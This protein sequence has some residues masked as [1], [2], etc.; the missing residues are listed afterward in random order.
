MGFHNFFAYID[1]GTGSML[2]T[3]ILGV[4][5]TGVFVVRGLIIKF[6]F[7]LG[8]GKSNKEN[9]KKIPYV[10]FSD[11]KRYWN[12]FKPVCDEFEKR[13]IPLSYL[14]ASPDDPALEESYQYVKAEF[15]GEGNKAFAR[16]NMM[17]AGTCL[18]TTPGLDVLQWKRS[19]FV[20]KYVHIFHAIDDGSMYRMF[21]LDYYDSVLLNAPVQE[22]PLRKLEELRN[23][24]PKETLVV[25]ST[26]LDAM[27]E[28]A[29]KEQ[30]IVSGEKRNKV[31]LCAP[32]WGASSILNRYGE[33]FLNALKKT[34]YKI[35][36]RP[37]PQSKTA[38]PELL[39][40]LQKKFPENES[41]EWNFDNDNFEVLKSADILISDFSGVV[42][43]YSFIF[44]KPIIYADTSLD[45]S[46]YDAAWLE[47]EPWLI[48]TLPSIG[49]QL[50]PSDF[51]HMK[52][53]IDQVADSKEYK[54]GR[55]AARD[56]GWS[57]R[58]SAAK[59][60]VDYLVRQREVT[61]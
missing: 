19:K 5:T 51:D 39:E 42:F 30:T 25:G 53:I 23:L 52:E 16:L 32:T 21:G 41:F 60:I 3:I 18:S 38:D 2:F 15:I 8:G 35:I 22:A 24:P 40:D 7:G 17:S 34:G 47:G 10:I 4:V 11:S 56:E 49:K 28:R 43:E 59:N 12:V 54:A 57:Q 29:Q 6:K 20:D 45:K 9:A 50:E 26:H 14:T 44:D 1:P 37:H 46:P 58:G 61:A 55:D 36:V 48:E 13:E 31:V 27:Q 33:D